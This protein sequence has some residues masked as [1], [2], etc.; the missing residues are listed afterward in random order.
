[1]MSPL[2][3]W[4]LVSAVRSPCSRITSTPTSD[5]AIPPACASVRRTPSRI[6]DHTATNSGPADCSSSVFS[7]WVCSSAQYCRV[8]KALIPVTEMKIMVPSRAR[9]VPQSRLRCFHANGR[10]MRK[11]KRPAQERQR[12]RRNMPGGEAADDGVAGPAQRGDAE[13]DV[14]LVGK[15]SAG[16]AGARGGIGSGHAAVVLDPVQTRRGPRPGA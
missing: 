15:P 14:R 13:Q 7:A 4:M 8:L 3:N 5:S 1:M 6:S 10:I 16:R 11:A 9:I 12:H 2:L